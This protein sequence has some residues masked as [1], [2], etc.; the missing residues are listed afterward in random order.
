MIAVGQT[1][2]NY[3]ITAKLGEG[4]MG[5]VF[6]AEHPVIGRKVA[7]KAI[8]PELSRNP[9]VVSRFV[10]EAKAVNQIGNEHI[11]DIH[12]FGTTTDGD[13]Y[14]IM[15]FLQGEALSDRLRREAPLEPAR[16]LGIAAQVADALAASH[17]HGIIHRDLKPENIFLIHKG[18]TTD[19]VKVLD[20]GLAK[21][22]LGDDKVSHKTR[23]GSVMGTPYYMSPEQCEGRPNIDHRADVYSLGVILF[24]MMTGKVPF[25]GEGYGE[26]IVKHI[27][28][29]IPSPRAIN[30]RIPAACESILLRALAKNRDERFRGMDDFRV[31]ML[32]PE[33]YAL[34]PSIVPTP[35]PLAGYGSERGAAPSRLADGHVSDVVLLGNDPDL[36]ARAAPMPSTFRDSAVAVEAEEVIPKS[37]TGLLAGI[38]VAALAAGGVAAFLVMR[39]GSSERPAVVQPAVTNPAPAPAPAPTPAAAPPV[40]P[41]LPSKVTIKFRSDPVGAAVARKD[42]GEQLG[43]TPFEIEVPQ[44][45]SPLAVVFKKASF[46]D[47][48]RSVV[49]EESASLDA[50]LE[51]TPSTPTAGHS[52]PPRPEKPVP[53]G[54]GHRPMDE[55]GVL[56]PSF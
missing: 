54:K 7:M 17:A 52:R 47:V 4:G 22:T 39:A 20:F 13:F 19:F 46:K 44:G 10:T 55:D 16:A 31:A 56:A 35:G 11:V 53:H 3:T 38:L 6:L 51:A 2:G 43:V 12:D 23:T 21:L 49:P 18:G 27:T 26:I 9:E 28:A 36:G 32:D 33:R 41:A 50:T 34:A 37:R 30:P 24:E 1:I 42:T 15:E 14:F 45:K 40:V 48:A 8:H 25:G 5:V 29:P